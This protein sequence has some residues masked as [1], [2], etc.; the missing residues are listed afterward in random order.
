MIQ[1]FKYNQK[2]IYHC[3]KRFG[4]NLPLSVKNMKNVVSLRR[5][6]WYVGSLLLSI[7]ELWKNQHKLMNM[8][9]VTSIIFEYFYPL[10]DEILIN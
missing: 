3:S 2:K 10:T 9:K 6:F 7:R 1:F 8:K 4:R 5:F